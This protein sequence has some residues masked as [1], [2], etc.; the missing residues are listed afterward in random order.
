MESDLV[1]SLINRPRRSEGNEA[2][3]LGILSTQTSIWSW[4]CSRE[5]TLPLL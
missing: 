3:E 5:T 2:L 1:E 4:V